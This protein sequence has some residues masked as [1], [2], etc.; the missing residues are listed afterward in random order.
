MVTA[1]LPQPAAAAPAESALVIDARAALVIMPPEKAESGRAL[2]VSVPAHGIKLPADVLLLG[3]DEELDFPVSP[4]ATPN[5]TATMQTITMQMKSGRL[6][7][8]LP[9]QSP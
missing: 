6:K 5:P 2:S 8:G 3:L 9:F 1:Q 4:S 7:H